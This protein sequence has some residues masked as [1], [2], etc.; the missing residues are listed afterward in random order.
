MVLQRPNSSGKI[1]PPPLVQYRD[2]VNYTPRYSDYLVWSG[3]FTTWHGV[4]TNYDAEKEEVSA[5]FSGI[6]F[7]LFTLND[8][9]QQSETR[10]IKLSKICS[11]SH[12]KWAVLQH[13]HANNTNIWYI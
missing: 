5:I 4:V 9:E 13:D 12:G 11:A 7:V 2:I 3:W 8:E 1:N 6:P 10:I